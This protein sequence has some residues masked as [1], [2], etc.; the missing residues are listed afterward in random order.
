MCLSSPNACPVG[1]RPHLISVR[2]S[3]FDPNLYVQNLIATKPIHLLSSASL[4]PD[5]FLF[6]TD[7]TSPYSTPDFC[8]AYW[9]CG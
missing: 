4:I 2:H 5:F 9:S 1:Q 6:I 7:L 8:G 3:T